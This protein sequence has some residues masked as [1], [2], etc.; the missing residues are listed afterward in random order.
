MPAR[1]VIVGDG[2]LRE[3]L[4]TAVER[5]GLAG[6]VDLLGRVPWDDVRRMYDSASVFLFTSL[7]DSFGAQFLEALGRGLPAVALAHHGIADVDAGPAAVKVALARRPR[8][9]PVRLA[10]ALQTVLGHDEWAVR[11]RRR[12]G[13]RARVARQGRRRHA[14]LQGGSA[15]QGWSPCRLNSSALTLAIQ[16]GSWRSGVPT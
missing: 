1:L 6:E 4:H 10:S 7:R 3:Q 12:L 5:R 9:L 15:S 2:P 14:D 8:D 13:S 11:S 16:S